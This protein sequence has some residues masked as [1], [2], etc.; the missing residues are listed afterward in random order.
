M[1]LETI[2]LQINDQ[3]LPAQPGETILQVAHRA[4]I[5]IPTLCHHEAL[6]PFGACRLCVVEVEKE[7]AVKYEAACSYPAEDGIA[8]STD[9]PEVTSVRKMTVA[10]LLSRCPEVPLIQK[11][12]ASLHLEDNQLPVSGEKEEECILCGR[13][14]RVCREVIDKHAVSFAYR[15]TQRSVSTPFGEHSHDCIGCTACAFVC[16]TGA[17]KVSQDDQKRHLEP[18]NTEINLVSCT[19]C[20]RSFAPEKVLEHL[21]VQQGEDDTE[22]L[23]PPCRRIRIATAFAEASLINPSSRTGMIKKQAGGGD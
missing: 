9:T 3:E 16:P 1:S 22:W 5:Y 20:G 13:C 15:G 23:C 7:G 17:I 18:W 2:T 8:V 14:V 12:A 4:G 19:E 6:A 11:L 21:Q 10:L